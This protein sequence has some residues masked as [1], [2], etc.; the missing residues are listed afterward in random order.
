[1]LFVR[2]PKKIDFKNDNIYDRDFYSPRM[3]K[4]YF[5]IPDGR[6]VDFYEYDSLKRQ[7]E[8]NPE[9]FVEKWGKTFDEY[10]KGA[11]KV[12][13]LGMTNSGNRR[14]VPYNAENIIKEMNKKGL[15]N[16]E[17]FDYGLSSLLARFSTKQNT[18]EQLKETAKENLGKKSQ[19]LEEKWEKIKKEYDDLGDKVAEYYYDKWSFYEVQSDAFYAISKN[20]KKTINEIFSKE[21]PKELIQEIK[22]FVDKAK[23]LPRSYFEAKP[24]REVELNEISHAFVKENVLNEKQIEN[25]EERGIKVVTYKEGELN[26]KLQEEDS[27]TNIYF[28]SA[29]HGGRVDFDRFD[30]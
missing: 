21:L 7:Y 1:M 8:S 9:K 3:P 28:Q 25:L 30:L 2:K 19:L 26:K 12:L 15:L 22:E 18:K 14:Y 24:M 17:G 4:P 10:F 29:F 5:D 23:K 6:V 27:T 20:M 11:K 13:Y 16:K